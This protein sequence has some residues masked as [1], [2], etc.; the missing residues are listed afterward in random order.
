MTSSA[1]KPRLSAEG[2][3]DVYGWAKVS[4]QPLTSPGKGVGRG[5]IAMLV[6]ENPLASRSVRYSSGEGKNQ[7]LATTISRDDSADS[8]AVTIAATL[9]CPP[10]SPTK[11]PPGFSARHTPEMTASGCVIQCN[12]AFENT[13]SNSWLKWRACPLMTCAFTLRDLAAAIMSGLESTP[14]TSHPRSKSV[15]VSAPSPQ[16][17]SRMRSFGCGD[18]NSTTGMPRSETKRACSA[19]RSGSQCC[20]GD[21]DMEQ[22]RQADRAA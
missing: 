8:M 6:T 22:L 2:K 21:E 10:N 18:S 15:M 5:M 17:R 20:A 13:A 19:Y 9:P 7:G 11:R 4:S 14:T 16:P 3:A 1:I 12:T